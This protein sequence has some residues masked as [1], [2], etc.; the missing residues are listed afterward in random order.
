MTWEG[1]LD[2]DAVAPSTKAMGSHT[3]GP[4]VSDGQGVCGGEERT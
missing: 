2:M 4:C 3:P 1:R